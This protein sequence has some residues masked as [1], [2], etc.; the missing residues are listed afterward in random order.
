[1]PD[2]LEYPRL[3]A[4]LELRPLGFRTSQPGGFCFDTAT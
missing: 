3:E 1:M 4:K 2:I